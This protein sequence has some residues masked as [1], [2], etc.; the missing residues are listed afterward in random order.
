M[1]MRGEGGQRERVSVPRGGF[2][3]VRVKG[4]VVL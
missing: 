3:G 4:D 2:V 1:Y